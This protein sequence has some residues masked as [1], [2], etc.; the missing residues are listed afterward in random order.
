MCDNQYINL[1]KIH[2]SKIREILGDD[3]DFLIHLTKNVMLLNNINIFSDT[4]KKVNLEK[5]K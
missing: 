5:I 1:K 4:S 3:I 2:I